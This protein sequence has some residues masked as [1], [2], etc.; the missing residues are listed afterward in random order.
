MLCEFAPDLAKKCGATRNGRPNPALL[1]RNAMLA[2]MR[3]HPDKCVE[4]C[5][6]LYLM[7]E[8]ERERERERGKENEKE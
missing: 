3:F 1:K 2:I 4:Y 6:P 8:K 5:L 7:R